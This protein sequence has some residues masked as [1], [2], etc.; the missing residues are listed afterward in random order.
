VTIW[1]ATG[2]LLLSLARACVP[3][4]LADSRS[5]DGLVGERVKLA[6]LLATPLEEGEE[7]QSQLL[8]LEDEWGLIE[9]RTAPGLGETPGQG[10]LRAMPQGDLTGTAER[11]ALHPLLRPVCAEPPAWTEH[12]NNRLLVGSDGLRRWGGQGGSS[13]LSVAGSNGLSSAPTRHRWA[14]VIHASR[15]RRYLAGDHSDLLPGLPP[16]EEL[17]FGVL[18]GVVEVVDCV[19]VGE[20]EGDPFAVGPWCWVLRNPR[21]I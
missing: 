15:S 6:G 21:P 20:V 14:L 2:P 11:T 13:P 5:L 4:G 3:P 10:P 9:I 1:G 19:P 7:D 8:T 17:H 16:A 12:V 18:V